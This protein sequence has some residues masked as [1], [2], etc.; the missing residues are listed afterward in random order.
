MPFIKN[1]LFFFGG[2]QGTRVRQDRETTSHLSHGP[3]CS[4]V[5]SPDSQRLA[6][7]AGRQVTLS[8]PFSNN[9]ID[10]G[11]FSPA[12]L[13]I[14]KQLPQTDNPCGRIV[15]GSRQIQDVW[16]AVGKLDYQL[17]EKH[18]L[19]ARYVPY[20]DNTPVPYS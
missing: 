20:Y 14:A 7:N 19:F 2:Y 13:N 12:A 4:Q 15:W 17:N 3:P 11:S 6:C 16:Q 9:R 5:I 1:K 8:A 18:S 10:P